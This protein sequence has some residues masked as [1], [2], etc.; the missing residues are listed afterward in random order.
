MKRIALFL[1][2]NLAVLLVL[3]FVCHLLGFDRTLD[4]NGLNFGALLGFSAVFGFGGAFISLFLSKPIAKMSVGAVVIDGSSSSTDAWLVETVRDLSE[5]AN[6]AMPEVAIYEGSPNAFAT[7]ATKNSSLIAVSTGLLQTMQKD[8]IRAVLA[9]E[10]AHVQNGD[11]VT[12]TLIQGIVNTFVIF[13]SRIVASLVSRNQRGESSNGI[14]FAVRMVCEIVFGILASIIVAWF[15]RQR[16][17]RADAGAA[18]LLGSPKPMQ[19]ALA[20]LGGIETQALPDS[21]AA[22][23][24]A[25]GNLMALFASH[26]PIEARIAALENLNL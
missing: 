14:Y 25:G 13:I 7:G 15:S 24:I 23:G 17:Y 19:K 4:E 3:G 8:E 11:M 16:E 10:M 12:L 2:T 22:F 26:P 20:K 5:R 21:L 18:H 9:H 1:A 6:L